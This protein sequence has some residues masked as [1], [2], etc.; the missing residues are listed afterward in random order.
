MRTLLELNDLKD[1]QYVEPYAGGAGLAIAL[2]FEEYACEIHLNDLSRA[3][4][5]FW[6]SVLNETDELCHRIQKTD[7]SISEWHRQRSILTNQ[8]SAD[9]LDL[10]FSTFFLNRTNRSGIIHL[11]GVIGG[12]D[13]SGKWKIDARYNK[14]DLV[15]RIR[16]IGRYRNRINI[17]NRDALKFTKEVIPKLKNAFTFFDPPYIEKG[18]D[19]YLNEYNLKSHKKIASAIS[20][21]S[22]PWVVT[23]DYAAVSHKL[24]GDCRRIVYDLSYS[25]R[26]NHKGREVMFLSK[27]LMVPRLQDLLGSRIYAQPQLSRVYREKPDPSKKGKKQLL[28][29]ASTKKS[30]ARS[31]Q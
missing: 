17:Y 22:S 23:Y 1:I 3:I 27:Q 8:N 30:S 5:A 18:A 19:L 2:L 20:K 31:I 12:L 28:K 25:A 7:V 11:G 29:S 26:K 14:D 6:H 9:L 15:Q 10:G 13:Q 16:R 24:Y 21:I 4:Y